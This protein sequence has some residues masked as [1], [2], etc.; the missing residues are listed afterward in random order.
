MLGVESIGNSAFEGCYRLAEIVLPKTLTE[1]DASAF[2][3]CTA[4]ASVSFEGTKAEWE[5]IE[6]RDSVFGNLTVKCSD[7]NIEPTN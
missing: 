3:N 1:I 5:S 6:K 7:G 4:L 2:N